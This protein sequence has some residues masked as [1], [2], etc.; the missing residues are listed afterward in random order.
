MD[1]DAIEAQE[2][3]EE[4]QAEFL[5]VFLDGFKGSDQCKSSRVDLW[6]DLTTEVGQV[7]DCG[8]DSGDAFVVGCPGHP[9][10]GQLVCGGSELVGVDRFEQLAASPEQADVGSEELVGRTDQ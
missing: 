4:F 6:V 9:F 8:A 5:F 10:S 1:R 2:S 7:F 3:V